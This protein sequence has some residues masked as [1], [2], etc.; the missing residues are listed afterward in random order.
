MEETQGNM[1]LFAAAKECGRKL[2]LS[3]S[4]QF[5]GGGSDGNAVS[6]MGIPTLD[7]LGGWGDGAHPK[8]NTC[9]Q[10]VYSA[11]R[12]AGFADSGYPVEQYRRELLRQGDFEDPLLAAALFLKYRYRSG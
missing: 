2:G 10:P 9:G 7:G 6:A 5:V 12:A 1:E 4:H 8:A 11:D 3:F